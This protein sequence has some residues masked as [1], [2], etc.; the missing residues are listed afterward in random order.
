MVLISP[1]IVAA[2]SLATP[3]VIPPIYFYIPQ[4]Y[5]PPEGFPE[6]PDNYW[7]WQNTNPGKYQWGMYNWTLQTY[8]F[9]KTDGF[10]CSLVGELPTEG[11]VITHR[12]WLAD[13]VR[14]NH[15]TLI[16][17]ILG[18]R[19]EHPYAQLHIVQNLK[20]KVQKRHPTLWD[21]YYLPHWAQSSL[22]RRNP[23]RGDRFENIAYM[24]DIKNLDPALREPAFQESLEAMGLRW[25]IVGREGWND[26]SEIDAIISVRRFIPLKKLRV[27]P[28]LKLCNAWHAGVPAILGREPAFQAER[29]RDLD[30]LEVNSLDE[31]L[32]SLQVLRDDVELRQAMVANG[33]LR[34]KETSTVNL[35]RRWRRFLMDTATTTY[36]R[37]CSGSTWDRQVFLQRRYMVVKQ[38]R[39]Q[40]RLQNTFNSAQSFRRKFISDPVKEFLGIAPKQRQSPEE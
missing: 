1:E 11:I 13:H 18:D 22:I 29:K 33:R 30:Y 16:I 6:H 4:R 5:F 38:E 32:N 37:W 26:Y 8:L 23:E 28:A 20:D 25:H 10:P 24:G 2:G 27:K 36:E 12:D 34:A 21:K 15:K 7:S 14:P 17:C 35:T 39:V 19:I 40:K 31:L 9:L 3:K